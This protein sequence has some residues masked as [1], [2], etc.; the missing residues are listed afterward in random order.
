MLGI[1]KRGDRY[2]RTLLIHGAR[3]AVYTSERR[4]EAQSVWVS[5]LELRPGANVATVALANKNTRV[6]WKLL[7][8]GEHYRS[9][10]PGPPLK[11][12]DGARQ[13]RATLGQQAGRRGALRSTSAPKHSSFSTVLPLER[14]D[15]GKT[16]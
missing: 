7:T 12:D 6:L 14:E 8:S 3:A 13:Q 15:G 10:P 4:R 16:V 5:R 1:S 11:S 9:M 2:L